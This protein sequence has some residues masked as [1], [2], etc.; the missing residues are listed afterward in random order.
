MEEKYQWTD[1]N[2]QIK[3]TNRRNKVNEQTIE[4]Y[5]RLHL[6]THTHFSINRDGEMQMATRMINTKHITGRAVL[7]LLLL[8]SIRFY[9]AVASAVA[10]ANW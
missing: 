7:L 8:L 6:H 5:E 1:T 9:F 10:V 2:S 4:I 3:P